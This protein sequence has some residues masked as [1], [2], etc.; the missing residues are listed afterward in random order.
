MKI[1]IIPS[2][3]FSAGLL[4]L[5]TVVLYSCKKDKV[6]TPDQEL[7]LFGAGGTTTS[8]LVPDNPNATFKIGLGVTKPAPVDRKINFSIT[9]PTG[10]VE[11]TQ[12]TISSKTVTIPA[13]KV[14]DSVSLKGIF[15]GFPTGRRDTLVF[16]ITGG[17]IPALIGSDVFKVVLQKFCP[18]DMTVFN[19]NF[20][21]LADWWE[22]YF[23]GDVVTISS[24]GNTITFD[25]PT[26]F[27]H[28]PLLIKVNPTTFATTVD[29]TAFGRYSAAG[30]IYTAKSVDGANSVVIPCDRIVSV[31]L[32][33]G[34][35]GGANYGGGLLRLRK[36]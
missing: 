24:S 4:L 22:D 10:A 15:A 32:N 13:G 8:Y 9:S 7:A 20:E 5:L 3:F 27:N 18:L 14:V 28:Q 34:S 23:P 6:V 21:V 19:G 35:T 25:Y 16:K 12:Y 29:L 11:G 2:I 26:P 36:L 1:K 31:Q 17:D 33:F 30:T